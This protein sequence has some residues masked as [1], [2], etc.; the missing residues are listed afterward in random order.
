M[1][2]KKKVLMID[3]ISDGGFV[4]HKVR[5]YEGQVGDGNMRR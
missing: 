4:D 1:R 3:L 5:L 2:F